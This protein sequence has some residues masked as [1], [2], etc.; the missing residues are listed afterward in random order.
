MEITSGFYKNDDG[1]LLHGPNYVLG[2][3]FSL[4]KEQKDEYAYPISGWY[5][6]SS[7][8]EA[9]EFFNLP[10]PVPTPPDNYLN[11]IGITYARNI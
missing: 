7:E 6:F 4:Y 9:R 11:N 5:W 10:K 3:S 2:G 8:E 1:M